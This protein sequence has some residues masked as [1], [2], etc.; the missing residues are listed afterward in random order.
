MVGVVK[1]VKADRGYLFL[2]VEGGSPDVFA[3]AK[4]FQ[5][6]GILFEES[7]LG[8]RFE[9]DLIAGPNGKECAANVRPAD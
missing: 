2:K 3:H 4:D 1:A 5:R 7:L 6:A 9:F 8:R